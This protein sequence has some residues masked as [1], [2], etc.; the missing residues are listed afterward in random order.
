MRSSSVATVRKTTHDD[1]LT[2]QPSN[3]GAEPKAANDAAP[4]GALTDAQ[5]AQIRKLALAFSIAKL[6]KAPA[7]V[8]DR[9]AWL[10]GLFSLAWR[11]RARIVR[12]PVKGR[13]LTESD[14]RQFGRTVEYLR[15]LVVER[16]VADVGE[17]GDA[18][19]PSVAPE[20]MTQPELQSALRACALP[21]C[22]AL[23]LEF[24]DDVAVCRVV[25]LA[26]GARSA[27][28]VTASYGV[29]RGV[30]RRDGMAGWLRTLPMGEAATCERFCALLDEWIKRTGEVAAQPVDERL[31]ERV[32]LL[33]LDQARRIQRVGR[34]LVASDAARKGD[35]ASFKYPRSRKPR[36]AAPKNPPAPPTR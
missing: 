35:Y 31:V 18:A 6:M 28:K 24:A 33:A 11:D 1:P 19:E 25:S 27:G 4:R 10:D 15:E 7:Y 3:D 16:E 13:V 14:L 2:D 9:V 5:R 26:R 23:A 20:E 12:V 34:Y 32:Y 29:L 30:L 8:H 36:K 22:D 21:L 17:P